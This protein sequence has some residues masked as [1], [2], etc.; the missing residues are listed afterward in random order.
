[1]RWSAASADDGTTFGCLLVCVVLL[2][3]FI[4]M[5]T[6]Y[7]RRLSLQRTRD[8]LAS[9]NYLFLIRL[10]DLDIYLLYCTCPVHG[11]VSTGQS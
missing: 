5:G 1:M 8:T 4:F 7:K 10:E 3:L 2:F 9:C 6:F 11:T